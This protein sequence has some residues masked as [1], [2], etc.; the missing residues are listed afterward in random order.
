MGNEASRQQPLVIEAQSIRYVQPYAGHVVQPPPPAKK[1]KTQNVPPVQQLQQ[2]PPKSNVIDEKAASKL[3]IPE[4]SMTMRGNMADTLI[5][6][7]QYIKASLQDFSEGYRNR[8]KDELIN[9]T[10]RIVVK[11]VPV[12]TM[13]QN[14]A[15]F[16]KH[17]LQCLGEITNKS[18]SLPKNS[19]QQVMKVVSLHTLALG[20]DNLACRLMFWEDPDPS[21]ITCTFKMFWRI[22]PRKS[23]WFSSAYDPIFSDDEFLSSGVELDPSLIIEEELECSEMF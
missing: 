4:M 22:A 14:N 2:I 20:H 18:Y 7:K 13:P 1:R 9:Y 10:H 12:G 23:N 17:F 21:K 3:M 5:E 15:E 16:I 6:F 11:D 19:M 8:R